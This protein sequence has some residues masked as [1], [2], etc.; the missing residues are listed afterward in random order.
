MP[1]VQSHLDSIQESRMSFKTPWR[2]L[3]RHKKNLLFQCT[4]RPETHHTASFMLIY[5]IHSIQSPL[6]SIQESRMPS[7]TTSR[8][9]W[10]H[11]KNLLLQC[12]Y[13]PAILHTNFLM[14]IYVVFYVQNLNF[15][16]ESRMSSTT[17]WRMLL[18]KKKNRHIKCI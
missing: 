18:R 15:A 13:R 2:M 3:W 10:R 11:K 5:A 4:W 14:F 7:K 6:D 16:Q 17:P 12:N 9:L 8:T 1:D